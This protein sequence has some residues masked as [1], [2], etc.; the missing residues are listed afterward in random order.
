MDGRIV[1]LKTKLEIYKAMAGPGANLFSET[2]IVFLNSFSKDKGQGH[3][4]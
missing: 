1:D 2:A 3:C 4:Q